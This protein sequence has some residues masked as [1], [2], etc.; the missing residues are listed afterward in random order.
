MPSTCMGIMMHTYAVEGR[1]IDPENSIL[2]RFQFF[3]SLH[4]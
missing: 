3:S 2:H 4:V 1:G